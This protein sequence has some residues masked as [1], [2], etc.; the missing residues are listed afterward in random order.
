MSVALRATVMMA[1]MATGAM[2]GCL[3]GGE[4]PAPVQ[5]P[6]APEIGNLTQE[7]T[8]TGPEIPPCSLLAGDIAWSQTDGAPPP[9]APTQATLKTD[10]YGVTHIYADDAYSLFYA[11]GYVQ[12]RDRLF[13]MDV[14]RLVG[15]GESARYLGPGQLPS[16]YEVHRDLYT[17]DE[18]DAQFA[19]APAAGQEILQAYADGVN[20]FIAEATAD[21]ALPS[22]FA[23][24]GR[25]P[26]AW[27]PQDS[28]AVI[29]YLIGYFGVAGGQELANARLLSQLED[30]LGE[31]AA[32]DAFGDYVWTRTDDTY[33]TISARDRTFNGCEDPLPGPSAASAQRAALTAAAGAVTFGVPDAGEPGVAGLSLVPFPPPEEPYRHDP[34]KGLMDG[35][36]WGSNALLVDGS[37]TATGEPIMWGAPQMSYYKPPI[38]YQVGLH[39]AGFDAA[40]MGVV[41]APGIVIGRNADIAWSATSGIEDQVDLV[42]V[43]LVGDRSFDWDGE[44][45]AMECWTVEHQT[46]PA[47]VDFTAAPDVQPVPMVYTQEVCRSPEGWP[48]VAINEDAGV[49]WLKTWTTRNEELMGA[50]KWLNVATTH[51]ID[52][53]RDTI[54]DFPFTFNFHVAETAAA[55]GDV[56]YIHTGDIPLR[57]DGFDARLPRPA[58][59]AF[60]WEGEAYTEDMDVWATDPVRGYFANWNNA[61]GWG[62]R[63]GDEG[64]LWGPVQRVQ[65][66]EYWMQKRLAETENAFTWQD[67]ADVNWLA[68]THDSLGLPFMP[69]LIEAAGTD[70]ELADV[71]QALIDWTALGLPWRD[72]DGDGL[73]DDPAHAVWDFMM[74]D[75]IERVTGDELGDQTPVLDLDPK[76]H[77]DPHAGD[78]GTLNTPLAPTL[79]AL[80]G[81][82]TH[83]W[84]DDITTEAHETCR[85]QLVAGLR[86]AKEALSAEHGDDVA[87]WLVPVH[88]S[89]FYP[90]GGTNADE[91]PMVNK[92][93]WV[94]VVSMAESEKSGSAAPPSN[95]GL[96]TAPELA[97]MIGTGE[98]PAHL[99]SE[100]EMYWNGEFK[101]FPLTAD[102][103]DAEA[104]SEEALFVLP[105]PALPA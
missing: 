39:G 82:T 91:V 100:L 53:F 17:A 14:L 88:T 77:G 4:D 85:E 66:I 86:A 10:A 97:V 9:A 15:Q 63:A 31:D 47:P 104:V 45:V 19:A 59:S 32:W 93:S 51:S 71:R 60:D 34:G 44:E 103:V 55:G 64:H 42:Q 11:N 18:V 87:D 7:P 6:E 26:P 49:A 2:A 21:N 28:V 52:E 89:R 65:Q 27:T 69:H 72:V 54:A 92:G 35:F 46:A 95:T 12:A 3:G 80:E 76:T 5:T 30:T 1:L 41:G 84:C 78:H 83:D 13:Q 48:V 40:G 16:D 20:R 105:P 56:A 74:Q 67:V 99:T 90:I 8:E 58:G 96:L 25:V 33:T 38:P 81:S 24:I 101:P 79:R 98:E 68:A 57:A 61:P 70:P 62:W 94:Q 29:N 102:E 36:H 43:D 75:M 73:Y 50:L 37:H 22:E 23:A